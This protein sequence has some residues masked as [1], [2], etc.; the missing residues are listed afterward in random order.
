MFNSEY[1]IAF[2]YSDD[3]HSSV[4]LIMQEIITKKVREKS[5]ECH[6]HKPQSFTGHNG[7]KLFSNKMHVVFFFCFFFFSVE[8][9]SVLFKH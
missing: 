2:I 5:R 6:N 1:N 7:P 3:A 4:H 8:L 9:Y